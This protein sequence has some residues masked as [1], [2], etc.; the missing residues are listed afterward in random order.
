MGEEGRGGGQDSG[1]RAQKILSRDT[2]GAEIFKGHT[3][4]GGNTHNQ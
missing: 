3:E 4:T 2:H 1:V